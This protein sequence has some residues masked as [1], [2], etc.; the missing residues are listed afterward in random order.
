[1]PIRFHVSSGRPDHPYST[2]W[3]CTAAREQPGQA[4][5]PP[6]RMSTSRRSFG[7]FR[8]FSAG[9]QISTKWSAIRARASTRSI[10]S[11]CSSK[12]SCTA[13]IASFTT[14]AACFGPHNRRIPRF[15]SRSS[16]FARAFFSICCH[17]VDTASAIRS[18]TSAGVA[19]LAT[20]SA[21]V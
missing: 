18:S 13:E 11:P 10:V 9:S 4:Q 7:I 12:Y 2:W 15:R 14:S 21:F 6:A 8:S 5:R 16:S 19:S 1:M 20:T 17:V 3:S